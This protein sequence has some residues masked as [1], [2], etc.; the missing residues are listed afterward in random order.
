MTQF[1]QHTQAS[2]PEASRPLLDATERAWKFVPTLQATL[3]ESPVS[4][5]GYSKLFELVGQSSLSPVEQQIAFLS[6]SVFHQC[7]YCTMGHTYLARSMKA[8]EQA[9]TAV[10]ESLPIDDPKLEALRQFTQAVIR[11]RGFVGDAATAR[12]MRAGF[13]QAQVLEVVLVIA[14]KTISNYVN[15]IAHTPKESFMDDPGLKWVSPRN[16]EAAGRPGGGQ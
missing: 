7:E 16:R 11:E 2:A 13:T 14:T 1:V 12:F 15:H 5:E 3:A 6:A 8:P 10:R 4:L 9:I